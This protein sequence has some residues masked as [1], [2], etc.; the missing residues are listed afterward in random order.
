MAAMRLRLCEYHDGHELFTVALD[1][2]NFQKLT[3]EP[4]FKCNA[5]WSLSEKFGC[6]E[7]KAI[8]GMSDKLG[9][10][11]SAKHYW[12]EIGIAHHKVHSK[13]TTTIQIVCGT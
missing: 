12:S 5:F 2:Q 1:T 3:F 4:F 13:E 7:F 11:A 10:M 9:V 8:A 6:S